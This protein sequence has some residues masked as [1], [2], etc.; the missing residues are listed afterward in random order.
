[1]TRPAPWEGMQFEE[2]HELFGLTIE[3]IRG[4]TWD[5][6][7]VE[8]SHEQT[9]QRIINAGFPVKGGVALNMFA[10]VE[11]ESGEYTK[12][13]HAN[14]ARDAEGRIV[15][16]TQADGR[17]TMRVKSIDLGFMQFNTPVGR[18]VEMTEEAV[19]V[20]VDEMWEANHELAIPVDSAERAYE[21]WTRRGFQPWYGYQPGTERFYGKKVYGA[22]AFANWLAHSQLGR[23]HRY[24][25]QVLNLDWKPPL[26]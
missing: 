16:T 13:W 25:G 3:E 2:G 4:I 23:R 7:G 8:L 21:L 11:G 6:D 22:K 10:I 1:M 20:F 9:I 24:S 17:V 19:A 14:V 26:T 12:A 5:L 15:R 18:D